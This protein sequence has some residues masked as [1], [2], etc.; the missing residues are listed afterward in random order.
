MKKLMLVLLMGVLAMPSFAFQKKDGPA[1]PLVVEQSAEGKDYALIPVGTVRKFKQGPSEVVVKTA[2]TV[3]H[4]DQTMMVSKVT[5]TTG[6]KVQTI[7]FTETVHQGRFVRGGIVVLLK[8]MI[9]GKMWQ[10]GGRTFRIMTLTQKVQTPMGELECLVI[11]DVGNK[12]DFYWAK[13]LGMVMAT[14]QDGKQVYLQLVSVK[15]P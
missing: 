6:A 9:K 12:V 7:I 13:G 5:M 1:P 15:K 10:S 3:K 4:G 2:T 11:R 14:S 8:K